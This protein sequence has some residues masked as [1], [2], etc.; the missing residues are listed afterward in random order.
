MSGRFG[1]LA[2]DIDEKTYIVNLVEWGGAKSGWRLWKQVR[3]QA[4]SVEEAK[5]KAESELPRTGVGKFE[6]SKA[7][8]A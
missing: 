1:K 8:E 6:V 7:K 4:S 3:V 5:K 2:L